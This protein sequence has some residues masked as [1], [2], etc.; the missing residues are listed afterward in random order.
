MPPGRGIRPCSPPWPP[1]REL[2]RRSPSERERRCC[3]PIPWLAAKGLLPGRGACERR[4]IEPGVAPAMRGPGLGA[5]GF[6]TPGFVAP[7]FGTPARPAA[8]PGFGIAAPGLGALGLVAPGLGALVLPAP[9]FGAAERGVAVAAPGFGVFGVGFLTGAGLS[10][11]SNAPG[12]A[13]GPR[14][15]LDFGLADFD[16]EVEDVRALGVGCEPMPAI[17]DGATFAASLL[18]A[19]P[20]EEPKCSRMRRT[21]G[22]SSDD[23]APLTYSPC[24]FSQASNSLLGMPN[25]FAIS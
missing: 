4:G 21:T 12:V 3:V 7:G 14:R 10:P 15:P 20:S 11:G 9:G 19:S 25:S 6:G 1:P 2:P 23:D 22:A 18:A 8:A 16:F 13:R 24:S 17:G 5:A